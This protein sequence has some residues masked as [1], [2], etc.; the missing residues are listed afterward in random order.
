M[1]AARPC[2]LSQ[3][4]R[5]LRRAILFPNTPYAVSSGGTIEWSQAFPSSRA[6]SSA[7]TPTL[8]TAALSRSCETPNFFDQVAQLMVFVDVDAFPVRQPRQY[9]GFRTLTRIF[10]GFFIGAAQQYLRGAMRE[11]IGSVGAMRERIIVGANIL[12]RV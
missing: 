11:N 2:H 7:M 5:A 3:V 12:A 9:F 10:D 8:L 6:T 4:V 1:A